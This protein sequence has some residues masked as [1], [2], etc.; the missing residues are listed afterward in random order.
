MREQD[1]SVGAGQSAFGQTQWSRILRSPGDPALIADLAA[2]YWRPVYKFLRI[3]RGKSND[4]AKDLTQDFFA[5]VVRPDWLSRADPARG[6]FRTFLLASL[7]NFVRDADKHRGALKRGG[8]APIVPIDGLED[9]PPAP[10][11]PE[12]A[13]LKSWAETLLADA[14]RELE[15]TCRPQVFR[16][17]RGYCIDTEPDRPPSYAQVAAGIGASVSEVTNW[18]AEARRELRRILAIKAGG[19]SFDPEEELRELFGR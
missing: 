4:D 13:F 6:S 12:R 18:I 2:S 3:A 11:D 19:Y 16:A 14:L 8:H 15:R 9:D 5:T 10:D 7:K 17:F 1:T